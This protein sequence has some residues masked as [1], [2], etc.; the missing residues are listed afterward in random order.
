MRGP[1][2][3]WH[4]GFIRSARF[5][6]G[7]P[8]ADIAHVDLAEIIGYLG[9]HPSGRFLRALTVGEN[10]VQRWQT[11]Y[12]PIVDVMAT[13][14]WP[15]LQSLVLG[16]VG[17]SSELERGNITLGDLSRL[18]PL[19]PALQHLSLTGVELVFGEPV[20]P[21]LLSCTVLTGALSEG[22][23]R[24][25]VSCD[26]P[27]LERLTVE[28][29]A[30]EELEVSVLEPLERHAR[31]RHLGLRFS[32]AATGGGASDVLAAFLVDSKILDRLETLDLS[33]GTLTDRGLASLM[34]S[35]ALRRLQRLDLSD[36]TLSDDALAALRAACPALVTAADRQR[37]EGE[38]LDG[39]YDNVDE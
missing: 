26:A 22:S 24:G 16:D 36:N 17:G 18:W 20:L 32:G 29:E 4:L 2:F 12:Q 10:S 33:R 13:Q 27:L 5:A 11:D 6:W 8:S 15:S 39:R 34:R 7:G 38:P 14:P 37:A 35:S 23:L 28:L 19:V 31:L 3:S 21:R 25:I 1:A 9:R 30:A